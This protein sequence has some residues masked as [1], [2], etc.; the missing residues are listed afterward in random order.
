MKEKTII[1]ACLFALL[2]ISGCAGRTDNALANKAD[3]KMQESAVQQAEEAAEQA[4]QEAKQEL[5][6]FKCT[7][8]NVQTF[9]FLRDKAKV[10][11]AA[12]ESWLNDDGFFYITEIDG[13]E[14][15]VNGDMDEAEVS[16]DSMMQTYQISQTMD[17]YDCQLN[18]VTEAD[19]TPPSDL[20][21]ITP[22]ELTNM[23]LEQ[24]QNY[25]YE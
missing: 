10:V 23:M 9:Y 2:L 6:N 4:E 15:L 20:E 24:M 3:E 8:A 13:K 21:I 12:G 16:F 5:V 11:S 17:N 19:V 7:I 25:G 22:E 14:Y 1:I 18:V